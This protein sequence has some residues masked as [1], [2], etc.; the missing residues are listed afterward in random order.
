MTQ[1]VK[2]VAH[3]TVGGTT[4]NVDTTR[5]DH[6]VPVKVTL[7]SNYAM[8]RPVGAP[9]RPCFTGA[10]AANLDYP[11]TVNSGVTLSLHK[12]EAD[13]LVTAGAASYA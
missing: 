2:N 3:G 10:S 6:S 1:N 13:A 4:I 7:S 11:R 5:I 8:V 12:G 9:T